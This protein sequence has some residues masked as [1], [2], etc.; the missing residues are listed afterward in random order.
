MSKDSPLL[1]PF[2]LNQSLQLEN[3]VVLAPLTRAR[4]GKESPPLRAL[5]VGAVRAL[6]GPKPRRTQTRVQYPRSLTA[7]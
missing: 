1:N 6:P 2:S 5:A 7:D 3:R 4:A